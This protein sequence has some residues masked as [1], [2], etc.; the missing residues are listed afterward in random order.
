MADEPKIEQGYSVMIF[1]VPSGE[2][3]LDM[4]VADRVAGKVDELIRLTIEADQ[5][6]MRRSRLKLD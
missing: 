2:V 6:N 4:K 3:I 5:K 1:R